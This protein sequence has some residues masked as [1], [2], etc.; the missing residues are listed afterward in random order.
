[1]VEPLLEF[2][3][4]TVSCVMLQ[5][6]QAAPDIALPKRSSCVVLHCVGSLRRWELFSLSMLPAFS[7]R[8]SHCAAFGA[9]FSA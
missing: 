7:G 2:S 6:G 5:N 9:P 3:V 1:M 4:H 8:V